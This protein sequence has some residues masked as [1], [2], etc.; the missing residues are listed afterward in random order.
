MAV[1][2]LLAFLTVAPA[3]PLIITTPLVMAPATVSSAVMSPPFIRTTAPRTTETI[4]VQLR[5]GGRVLWSGDL[6]RA[7]DGT[8]SFSQQVRESRACPD[9]DP[10]TGTMGTRF[11]TF[12]V[13]INPD[14]PNGA[15]SAR[16]SIERTA[17]YGDDK[18][19]GGRGASSTVRLESRVDLPQGK[20][21][22]LEG[23][24]GLSVTLTRR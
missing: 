23:E 2:P 3:P 12:S 16:V 20:P 5:H 7:S 17:P 9:A 13:S 15:D 19:C 6:S 11:T 4:A 22:T 10:R 14:Y 21:V 1:I 18:D 24:G 8:A